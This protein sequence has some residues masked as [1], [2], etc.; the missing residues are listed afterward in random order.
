MSNKKAKSEMRIAQLERAIANKYSEDAVKNPESG[1]DEEKEK[2][3]QGQLK[4]LNKRLDDNSSFEDKVEVNGVLVSKKLLSRESNRTCPVC[5][6]YSFSFKD[7]VYM[8]K[9]E[10]CFKCYIQYVEN[11]EERWKTGW[12]P[13]DENN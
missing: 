5:D 10:C 9:F 1:W 3:F 8:T 12:R 4:N 11:R 13:E 7:D 2:A 6:V